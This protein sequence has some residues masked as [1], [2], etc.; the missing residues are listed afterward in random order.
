MVKCILTKKKKKNCT[1]AKMQLCQIICI[2]I[3]RYLTNI[4]TIQTSSAIKEDIIKYFNKMTIS[5]Q[6][7]NALKLVVN[8]K[9]TSK[10]C[11]HFAYLLRL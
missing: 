8:L 9:I 4:Q 7:K 2:Y 11:K 5:I 6:N 3:A 1:V 10:Q